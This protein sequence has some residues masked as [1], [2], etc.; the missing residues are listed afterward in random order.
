MCFAYYV[1][2]FLMFF[3]VLLPVYTVKQF[4]LPLG[5]KCT[6]SIHLPCL[7]LFI[8]YNYLKYAYPAVL[9]NF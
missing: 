6:I 2:M 3:F 5:V 7:A 1:F 9:V 8:S 4:G